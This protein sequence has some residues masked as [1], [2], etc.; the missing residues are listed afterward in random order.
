MDREASQEADC[1]GID[2]AWEYF[3]P[4]PEIDEIVHGPSRACSG[5]E[6]MTEYEDNAATGRRE[7]AGVRFGRGNPNGG[8]FK[9]GP[10][11]RDRKTVSFAGKKC[12]GCDMLFFPV[13]RWQVY[14]NRECYANRPRARKFRPR[15][16][17]SRLREHCHKWKIIRRW[18]RRPKL[19]RLREL[20]AAGA[21]VA[22]ISIELNVSPATV[23][24]WCVITGMGR[25]TVKGNYRIV[26][27]ECE[28]CRAPFRAPLAAGKRFCSLR[29][30]TAAT[31]GRP[32][33][34]PDER[35]ET[36][37]GCRRE[38]LRR[39]DNFKK[40]C[41]ADCARAHR[42]ANISKALLA[43]PKAGP[44]PKDLRFAE[45]WAAGIKTTEIAAELGIKRTNIDRIRKRLGLPGRNKTNTENARRERTE[46]TGR[47]AAGDMGRDGHGGPHVAR[48]DGR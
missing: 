21:P 37:P 4:D 12:P 22:A 23:V 41:S 2:P 31:G 48:L 45:L 29:C 30:S 34:L 18:R 1:K 24:R 3:T 5:F 32:K 17:G 40:Y 19:R 10:E 11:K 27:G 47:A 13:S 33:V 6:R 42:G 26:D 28:R 25:R 15:S 20:W 8:F 7:A 36:C 9:L 43:K 14:C 16:D 39:R 35:T 44:G 38:W 46:K